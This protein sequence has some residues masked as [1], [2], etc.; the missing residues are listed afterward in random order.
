MKHEI[1][2]GD[3]V[4]VIKK[5]FDTSLD[6]GINKGDT[7]VV[8]YVG[9]NIKKCSVHIY[10]KKN[11]FDD[12]YP[13]LREHG[14]KYDY[15]IPIDC[16]KLLDTENDSNEKEDNKMKGIK[17]QKIVDLHFQRKQKEVE[18]EYE[19]MI[20]NVKKEDKNQ[21]FVDTLECQFN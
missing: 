17:N 12:I 3:K 8:N 4:K 2:V 18:K 10:G 9:S 1:K 19:T 6:I 20:A 11:T 16:M 15:W 21:K 5:P 7:G 14:Q 13:Q